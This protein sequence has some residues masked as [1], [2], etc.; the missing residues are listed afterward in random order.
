VPT[1]RGWDPLAVSPAEAGRGAVD[2]D[3][4]G[5]VDDEDPL[6]AVYSPCHY[7]IDSDANP[8]DTDNCPRTYNPGQ[9]DSD[10]DSLGDACDN[11]PTIANLDQRDVD[12]LDGID[13]GTEFVPAQHDGVGDVC[14][15][16]PHAVDT[17]Q[18]NC[19]EDAELAIWRRDGGVPGTERD[20]LH[21]DACDPTPCADTLLGSATRD[22]MWRANRISLDAVAA[23]ST[24]ARTGFR[25]CACP[26]ALDNTE[27][28]R[29]ACERAL[30]VTRDNPGGTPC[31]TASECGPNGRCG[32][33]GR[34]Q[35][36]QTVGQCGVLDTAGYRE[37]NESLTPWRWTT[38]AFNSSSGTGV[39]AFQTHVEIDTTHE[40]AD[41][42]ETFQEDRFAFWDHQFTD[43]P[44]WQ[45]LFSD[46]ATPFHGV[47]WSHTP[48]A[49]TLI[50]VELPPSWTPEYASHFTSGTLRFQAPVISI[51]GCI[52]PAFRLPTSGVIGDLPIPWVGFPCGGYDNPAITVGD[53][54]VRVSLPSIGLPALP[55]LSYDPIGWIAAAEPAQFRPDLSVP[56]VALST[57]GGRLS[58]RSAFGMFGGA[59]VDVYTKA[60]P[61]CTQ[62]LI[63]L[64]SESAPPLRSGDARVLSAS[65]GQVFSIG[66]IGP[67]G[68]LLNEAWAFD[69]SSRLWRR[70]PLPGALGTVRAATFDSTRHE[71]V[72]LDE[73]ETSSRGSHGHGE[74]PRIMRIL[75]VDPSGLY[76]NELATFPRL[77]G[78][79]R[80]ALG[81]D[82]GGNI[83]VAA[84]P[85]HTAEHVVLELVRGPHDGTVS[86]GRFL[87][88]GRGRIAR[89]DA[90]RVERNGITV[91]VEDPRRG[92]ETRGY[93][94]GELGHDDHGHG[95]DHGDRSRDDGH[96]SDRDDHGRDHDDHG[97]TF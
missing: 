9:D 97:R 74:G 56:L 40:P 69:L 53:G 90:I 82:Q 62:A 37:T 75:R 96:G 6:P 32:T 76:L 52:G 27:D 3:A 39:G 1:G 92:L 47:L 67:H 5:I 23:E 26:L 34:C 20:Y 16:C 78:N 45:S 33:N 60:C 94:F 65:L 66:G 55:P 15:I 24:L 86:L 58:V 28:E 46:L 13:D 73:L 93:R 10:G 87:A 17:A 4:D 48:R 77:S 36:V 25:Y 19:N 80:F 41:A 49:R 72:V 8:D 54:G 61:K 71:L 2:R 59:L 18:A 22:G 29:V 42:S 57:E 51:P 30:D 95:G 84:S 31:V 70:L 81:A 89:G 63:A 68:D 50:G 88:D 12:T 14:D 44:R 35:L 83:W 85:E 64:G 7:D 91:V 11:C 43:M 21:G 79:D 38:M